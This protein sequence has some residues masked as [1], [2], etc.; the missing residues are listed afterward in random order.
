[1]TP[2]RRTV[3]REAAGGCRSLPGSLPPG[4][5]CDTLPGAVGRHLLFQFSD[6]HLL[7][8]GRLPSGADPLENLDRAIDLIAESSSRPEGTVLSGDLADA[9]DPVAYGLLRER[10]ER[11][12]AVT[13]APVISIPGNHDDR[14]AVRSQLLAEGSPAGSGSDPIDQVHWFGGLRLISLDSVIPGSDAGAL[15][16][17]QLQWLSD[18]LDIP[19]GDGT[20]LAL[21]HPPI[22]SPIRSMAG[23][24]LARP[25]ELAEVVDGSDVCLVV[26]GHNHHASAGMLGSVPVWVSPA[27]SYRSDP[28]EEDDYVGRIGSAFSRIDLVDGHPLVTFVPVPS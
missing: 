13:E 2:G 5:R 25:E 15:N 23:M 16:P 17:A 18:E 12:R 28:L 11:L 14:G 19:A 26:A 20:V 3:S 9:G 27:L 22:G 1:M 24:A 21:H 4:D 8:R 7:A 10:I 6:L